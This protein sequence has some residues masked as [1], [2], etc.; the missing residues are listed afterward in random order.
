[1]LVLNN[2]IKINKYNFDKKNCLTIVKAVTF[3]KYLF[4]R[5]LKS[6]DIPMKKEPASAKKKRNNLCMTGKLGQK[7]NLEKGNFAMIF[8]YVI[9]TAH[10]SLSTLK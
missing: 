1:M 10:C 8:Q 2:D 6:N 4:G 3:C 5:K 7:P 9:V